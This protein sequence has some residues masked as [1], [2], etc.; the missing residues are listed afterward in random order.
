[1]S[2]LDMSKRDNLI[3]HIEGLQATLA[4]R[5]ARISELEQLLS[6]DWKNRAAKKAEEKAYRRG[7]EECANSMMNATRDCVLALGKHRKAA[8]DAYYEPERAERA[9]QAE[10]TFSDHTEGSE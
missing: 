4:K 3:I 9:R 2:E 10:S 1:M 8:L 7:W 6:G 5:N